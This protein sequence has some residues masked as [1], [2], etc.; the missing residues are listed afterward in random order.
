MTRE[1]LDPQ[2][3]LLTCLVLSIGGA[4]WGPWLLLVPEEPAPPRSSFETVQG[5]VVSVER[6]QHG[7]G[8]YPDV[9]TVLHLR[10]ATG[11][12]DVYLGEMFKDERQEPH[13]RDRVTLLY[14]TDRAQLAALEYHLNGEPQFTLSDVH[15]SQTQH[16][17][18]VGIVMTIG[19]PLLVLVF[20]ARLAER[21]KLLK[22]I[23]P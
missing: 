9:R 11:P 17:R 7:S 18:H 1:E 14:P 10:T 13:A 8:R 20:F 15:S 4:A 23:S 22:Q 21:R 2:W 6:E 19:G 12:R 3:L 5:T 16:R